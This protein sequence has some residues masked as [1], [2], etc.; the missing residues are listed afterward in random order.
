MK[1]WKSTITF[2]PTAEFCEKL[3]KYCN[4]N[5]RKIALSRLE[6]R[7]KYFIEDSADTNLPIIGFK[8]TAEEIVNE[9]EAEM[10]G[11]WVDEFDFDEDSM[12]EVTLDDSPEPEKLTEEELC[13]IWLKQNA[14]RIEEAI[15]S[16][17]FE[18]ADTFDDWLSSGNWIMK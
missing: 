2:N 4:E 12:L 14:D 18:D 10:I 7:M 5:A 9:Y 16:T 6:R 13:Q 17:S 1:F 3:N 11:G 8:K 15:K